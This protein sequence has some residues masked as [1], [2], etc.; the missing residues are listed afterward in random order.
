MGVATTLVSV[1]NSDSLFQLSVGQ[2]DE[3]CSIL[4]W[5]L[6]KQ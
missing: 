5:K 4:M 6:S 3:G 1:G 2:T